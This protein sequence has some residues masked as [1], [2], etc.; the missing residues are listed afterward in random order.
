MALTA[1]PNGGNIG[2]DDAI[3]ITY[4]AA[5]SMTGPNGDVCQYNG[6]NPSDNYEIDSVYNPA[7]NCYTEV[8]N[9]DGTYHLLW[10][11]YANNSCYGSLSNTYAGCTASGDFLG[12]DI[13]FCVG[14]SCGGG[15]T[16]SSTA[17]V[18]RMETIGTLMYVVA[19]AMLLYFIIK[20]FTPKRRQRV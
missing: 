5:W 18:L 17:P 19:F 2:K 3:T 12:T 9:G 1:S 16:S 7:N 13:S 14:S 11:T 20:V 6:G 10:V 15:G 4:S 8:G